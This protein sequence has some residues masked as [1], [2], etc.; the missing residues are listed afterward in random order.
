MLFECAKCKW[1]CGDDDSV[2]GLIAVTNENCITK[3]QQ[4]FRFDF[5]SFAHQQMV[6][7]ER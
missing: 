7:C 3:I 6:K 1:F 5:V 2:F 4:R